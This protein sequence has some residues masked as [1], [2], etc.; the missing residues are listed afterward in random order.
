MFYE[1]IRTKQNLS[2]ISICPLS[3]LYNS[4]FVLMTTPLGTNAVVKCGFTVYVFKSPNQLNG[5]KGPE[6][7]K[8]TIVKYGKT[9]NEVQMALKLLCFR[10][11]SESRFWLGALHRSK[12]SNFCHDLLQN[13]LS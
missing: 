1:E 3:I 8:Y 10:H 2:Y 7:M 11:I 5:N 4:K 12:F 13:H 9:F 6:N